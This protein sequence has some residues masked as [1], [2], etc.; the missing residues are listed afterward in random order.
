[1]N[2][3]FEDMKKTMSSDNEGEEESD[4]MEQMG[5]PMVIQGLKEDGSLKVGTASQEMLMKLLFPLLPKSLEVGESVDIPVQMPFFNSL[6]S[7]LEVK[8]CLR[9]KLAKYVKI[10][11]RTCAQLNTDIDISEVDIPSEL[12]GEYDCSIKGSSVFYFDIKEQCFVC[13]WSAIV[14]GLDIDMPTPDLGR[15]MPR[16]PEGIQISMKS[17]NLIGLMLVDVSPGL[18]ADSLPTQK[19][20][21]SVTRERPFTSSNDPPATKGSRKGTSTVS[22]TLRLPDGKG[23]NNSPRNI[24]LA[25]PRTFGKPSSWR[26]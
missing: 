25:V 24:S 6:G 16:Q 20:D 5:Q 1:A 12:E 18:T 21:D 13:G 4:S 11:K 2:L 15:D 7:M 14:M 19:R 22:P 17:D 9:M 3:V 8:G 26:P 23:Q 10:G